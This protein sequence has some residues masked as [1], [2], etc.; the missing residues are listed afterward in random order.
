ME[1][2]IIERAM[3]LI[4]D[5]IRAQTWYRSEALA[6]FDGRTA[7]ELVG[8]GQADAV[9]RHLETLELGGFA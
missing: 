9:L 2:E 4:G 7:E 1:R 8:A 3:I 6:G 5:S